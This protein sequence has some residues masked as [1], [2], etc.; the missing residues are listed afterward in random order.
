MPTHSE[1]IVQHPKPGRKFR[2]PFIVAFGRGAAPAGLQGKLLNSTGAVVAVGKPP[3]NPPSKH[4]ALLFSP[5]EPGTGYKLRFTAP[6]EDAVEVGDLKVQPVFGID[7]DYPQAGDLPVGSDFMVYGATDV[8]ATH[9]AVLTPGN[10]NGALQWGPPDPSDN[11]LFEFTEVAVG[12]Y[13]VTVSA[14]GTQQQAPVTV[15]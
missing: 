1:I 6:G 12:N 10:I 2:H 11:Y 9:S 13:T 4:W 15:Q 7:I 14:G 8:N 5:V 3:V